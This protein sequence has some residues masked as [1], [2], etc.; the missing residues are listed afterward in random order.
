MVSYINMDFIEA[1]LSDENRVEAERYFQDIIRTGVD[2]KLGDEVRRSCIIDEI[3]KDI[4][5]PLNENGES[6]Q[7][8]LD[9]FKQEILPFCTNFSSKRFM[10]FPDAG[11][12]IGAIGG[13]LLYNFLQQNLINQSFCAPSAT[14]VEGAVIQW[15]RDV[16]GYTR[17]QSIES[18]W[19]VGGIITAGGTMSN[20]VA[21]M[22]ARENKE[23]GTMEKG[24]TNPENFKLVVPKGIG[25]YSVKSA[26]MWVGCG[27]NLIEVETDNFR[28]NLESLKQTLE[29]HGDSIMA[30][31]VYVG[32]SRTMTI[33][34]L[35]AVADLVHSV[36]KNIWLHADACHGFSLGFSSKLKA[37]LKGIEK[38]DS[39]STDPHKVL[40][41]P[42]TISALLVKEPQKMKAVTSTSDLIM[43][44]QY[45]FGQVTPF[46]GSKA[47]DSL[48]LW[49][50]M[51]NFG[52]KGLDKLITNRHE[53]ALYLAEKLTNDPDFDVLNNVEINSVAFFYTHNGTVKNIE[54]LNEVSR[55]IHK[56][57]MAEGKYHL[58][59]FSVPDP[60]KYTRGELVYPL[61]F[62]CGN[63]N[64]KSENLDDMVEYVR[65]LGKE[66]VD[67]T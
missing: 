45:A 55:T 20:A 32:D 43:Q 8:L 29:E 1:V 56:R 28:Y 6:L 22:L 27:H 35:D 17:P 34:N 16:V 64:V 39:I 52:T 23:P 58:H 42:Y 50:M 47:W 40:L 49:F 15:L 14:F 24:M 37:K 21:I 30:V 12:S 26:Q 53:R 4:L 9:Q 44:E 11:N 5:K 25:H 66:I 3:K 13:A 2:F 63:P 65:M 7:L 41:T 18:V 46:T 59:Q 57:L 54:K 60:G 33:E 61:R 19:D 31:V 38:F 51:K 36:N 67:A 48:K 10:G 62:M